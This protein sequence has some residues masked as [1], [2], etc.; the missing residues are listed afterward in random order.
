MASLGLVEE[1]LLLTLEDEGGEFDSIPDTQLNCGLA[2]A[3]L[4]DLAL[5][6]R[7]DSDLRQ[8]WV[9]DAS[10]TGEKVLDAVLAEIAKEPVPLDARGWIS[11]FAK[12]ASFIRDGALASL[13]KQGVLRQ[14]DHTYLWVM[15]GRRYPTSGGLERQ[16]AK[17]R[18]LALLFNDEL[19]DPADI[20]LVALADACGV[21]ERILSPSSLNEAR[22]RIAQLVRMDLIGGIIAQTAQ[23]MNVEIRQAER[24]TVLAGLAGN[25]MEWY[26][27]GVY[28]FFAAAIGSQ[29]FPSHDPATS[30]LASFSVFA[31][32]FLARPLGGVMFGHIGDRMGRR[33]AVIASC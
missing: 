20:S 19:P 5:R 15:K 13:I 21:F 17:R 30:L 1:F 28:G 4:M 31:V 6:G 25:V 14:E 10:P 12:D 16:E 24:R 9:S 8:L 18:I 3:V 2:S 27:F 26:D 11:R 7:I 22:P 33:F 23:V 32:G 29:F